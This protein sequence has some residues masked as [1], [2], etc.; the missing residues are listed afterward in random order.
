MKNVSVIIPARNEEAFIGACLKSVFAQPE[1]YLA[2]VIVAD[3][4][5]DEATRNVCEQYNVKIVPGGY[6][7]A[8]RN[9][10]ARHATGEFLLFL[11]ADTQLPENFFKRVLPEFEHRQLGVA[12]FY[13]SPIPAQKKSKATLAV[14]NRLSYMLAAIHSPF[15][16]TA[17][18]SIF[19]RRALHQS[20]GGFQEGPT[21]LEEYDYIKRAK[22]AGMFGVM[23]I[24]VATSMRRFSGKQSLKQTLILFYH[25]FK[26]MLTGKLGATSAG[27]LQE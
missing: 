4:S 25:Y 9:N 5:T 1:E 17:G 12:S 26:W 27:Y 11:D 8:A 13:L 19:V 20:I 7:A 2:E 22:G 24:S 15:F 18:C 6:P 10:G 21:V 16:L 14:Y 3:S 23:K